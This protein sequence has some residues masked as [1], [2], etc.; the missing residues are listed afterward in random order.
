[1]SASTAE[2][3]L[4]PRPTPV[5]GAVPLSFLLILLLLLGSCSNVPQSDAS[6]QW[7]FN[8]KLS[9]RTSTTS[10]ILSLTWTQYANTSE[11]VLKGPLGIK[12]ADISAD[13]DGFTVVSGD[14][15][16]YF[17][18]SQA[19]EFPDIGAIRLPWRSL[20][21]WV[22]GEGPT[23]LVGAHA[24]SG[25]MAATSWAVQVLKSDTDGPSLMTFEH[26]QI[27]LRLSISEWEFY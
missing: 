17:S 21:R 2:S 15:S 5:A 22:R 19:L 18:H 12:V 8:G 1:M 7:S 3:S 14:Q 25:E 4:R 27:R 10:R 16:R 26:P 24:D 23:G 20:A 9:V 11:I 6:A 13:D